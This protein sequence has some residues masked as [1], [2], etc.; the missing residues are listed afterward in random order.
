[1]TALD[2]APDCEPHIFA[3]DCIPDYWKTIQSRIITTSVYRLN[4]LCPKNFNLSEFIVSQVTVK[5]LSRNGQEDD[6]YKV[7]HIVDC[8]L[9]SEVFE[10]LMDDI[11]KVQKETI[12]RLTSTILTFR[13][14][15]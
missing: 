11:R 9:Q 3:K 1:M 8:F 14:E 6:T 13:I 15:K 7:Q 5:N 4:V 12:V 10:N 2:S